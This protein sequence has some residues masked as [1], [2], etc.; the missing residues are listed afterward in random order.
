MNRILLLVLAGFLLAGCK[1][2]KESKSTESTGIWVNEEKIQGKTFHKIFI[3][4]MT[5][6]IEARV[7]L[8][9]D[10]AAVATTRGYEAVKSL[11][12]LPMS[13]DNPRKPTKDEVVAKVKESGS[14]AVFLASLLRQ[15]EAIHY[16]P[17]TRA[18]SMTPYYS[19]V[20]TYYGYYNNYYESVSKPA[21][22]D[23]DK[24]FFMQSN[25]YDAASEEL[26]WSVQ[27]EVFNPADLPKFSK[28]YT[29]SLLKQLEKIKL[30]RKEK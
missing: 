5:A 1:S 8:E 18:Y 29:E 26:M 9:N 2:S 21:Y 13:L 6:D 22:Y 20:G 19:Y 28:G 7:R 24:K 12:L 11:D 16:V 17:G 15:E 3:V 10:L 23:H 4:V 25:L 30:M 14:D 27:S